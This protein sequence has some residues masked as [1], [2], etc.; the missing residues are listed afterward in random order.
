MAEEKRYALLPD[1]IALAREAWVIYKKLFWKTIGIGLAA[2]AGVVILSLTIGIIGVVGF[3]SLGAKFNISIASLSGILIVLTI[4]GI[5]LISSWAMA[6]V[7][8]LISRW[9]KEEK[10]RKLFKD[11]K[12]LIIPFFLTSILSGLLSTGAFFLFIIPGIIFS[13]WF[14][15]WKFVFI[16]EGKRGLAAL[17]ASREYIRGRFWGVV[18]RAIAVYLPMILLGVIIS[19]EGTGGVAGG[20]HGAYELLSLFLIPFYIMYDF[21]LFTYLQKTAGATL[22]KVPTKSGLLY[23][24]VPV[25]GYIAVVLISIIAVPAVV[26][27]IS[28]FGSSGIP[29]NDTMLSTGS[30]SVKSS[31]AIVY[32][33]TNYY[34]THKEFP[35][36]LDLLTKSKILT[37]IPEEPTTNKQYRYSVLKNGQD[38]RL[39]TPVSIQPEKCVSTESKSFDL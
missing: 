30:K 14:S 28:S 19:R 4:L 6:A 7:I 35:T 24:A 27:F 5:S 38:F 34:L 13:I 1:P 20:I 12:P 21:V 33:L 23:I 10:I 15:M 26:R 11:S 9:R 22:Q 32:G 16:L 29:G 39:C 3:F 18:W 8:L 36:N 37:T 31:T 2:L 25:I 17:H